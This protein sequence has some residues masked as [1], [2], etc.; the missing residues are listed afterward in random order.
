MTTR[1]AELLDGINDPTTAVSTV[2]RVERLY[3]VSAGPDVLS[4]LVT[5]NSPTASRSPAAFDVARFGKRAF[6]ANFNGARLRPDGVE[7]RARFPPRR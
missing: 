6:L 2:K 3:V 4:A 5:A 1:G 7:R